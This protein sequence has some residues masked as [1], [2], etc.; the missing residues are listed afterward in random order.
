[1]TTNNDDIGATTTRLNNDNRLEEYLDADFRPDIEQVSNRQF[2]K[3]IKL[4]NKKSTPDF[5]FRMEQS[6]SNSKLLQF[7]V[8]ISR[9]LS[10][11]IA[12]PTHPP[13]AM[14]FLPTRETS[15]LMV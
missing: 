6:N 3:F 12:G 13:W 2:L 9:T 5:R 14:A 7:V 8:S 15:H 11:Y 4:L 10:L 1:M